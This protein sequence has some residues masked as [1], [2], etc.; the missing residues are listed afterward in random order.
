MASVYVYAISHD[1]GFAPNPFGGFC[2]LA[3]C[4]P[5]IRAR[6]KHGDWI[7][8]L[9]GTKLRPAMRCIYAM[10]VTGDMT[11]DEY[12][13]NPEFAARRPKRN[14]TAKKLVGDNIYHRTDIN[15]DWVQENSVHSL[16]DGSQCPINTKHDTRINRILVSNRFIYFGASAQSL[17]DQIRAELT[18]ERNVRDYRRYATDET[19]RL[20]GWLIPQMAAHPNAVLG[21]P[22]N[23]DASGR[24]YSAK[25]KRMT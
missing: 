18:Y 12:W 8:G 7:V 17:P 20:I 10:V 16:E 5:N 9:T 4:K 3:C 15:A 19:P 24:R 13:N 14:G 25:L 23:F 6:A 11:F 22:I 1:L 21:D 2:T